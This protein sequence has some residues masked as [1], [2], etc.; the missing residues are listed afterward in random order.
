MAIDP[1]APPARARLAVGP[2][3]GHAGGDGRHEA[4]SSALQI[5]A[6][7]RAQTSGSITDLPETDPARVAFGRL[8]GLSGGLMVGTIALGLA[9]MWKEM[10]D[11]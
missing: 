6:G 10:R 2:A 11:A 8:H 7:I 5:D 1:A 9:L 3:R 4:S